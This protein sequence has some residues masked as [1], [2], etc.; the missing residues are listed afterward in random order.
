MSDMSFSN[1]SRKTAASSDLTSETLETG[2]VDEVV[3]RT[4]IDLKIRTVCRIPEA[5]RAH[6]HLG[7]L[8]VC[9]TLTPHLYINRPSAE[10]G[11]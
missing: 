9:V 2:I 4:R 10:G 6:I 3:A 8:L 7:G 5:K 1:S 11:R